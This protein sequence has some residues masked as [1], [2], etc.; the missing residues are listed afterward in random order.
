MFSLKRH[1]GLP[2]NNITF[3]EIEEYLKVLAA[4]SIA[5]STLNQHINAIKFYYEQVLNKERMLFYLS[6]PKR[7]QFLPDILSK[8]EVI[9]IF[10]QASN[11]KHK[12]MLFIAYSGGLRISEVLKL[13]VTDIDSDRMFLHIRAAKG[14]KDRM[15]SLSPYLL[16]QLRAYFIQYKPKTYLFESTKPGTPYSPSSLR[17]VFNRAK[18]KAKITKKVTFHSLRHS[19]A[20]HLLEGGIDL[21]YI[22]TLL[23]HSDINTTLRYTHV[24]K[25]SIK[26][27]PSP[28]DDLFNE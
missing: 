26:N 9:K 20:T 8:Q 11:E 18:F 2:I 13:K 19:Y 17:N 22:Q 28:L 10:N 12:C 24:T 21:R 16:S 25:N 4:T 3:H 5:D 27:I 7:S 1:E 15:V 6:R 23:G 14:K